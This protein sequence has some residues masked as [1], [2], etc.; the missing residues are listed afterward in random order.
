MPVCVLCVSQ[1][2]VSSVVCRGVVLCGGSVLA[3]NWEL[4][5]VECGCYN[6]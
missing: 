4:S 5:R 1:V 2:S 6:G 3:V